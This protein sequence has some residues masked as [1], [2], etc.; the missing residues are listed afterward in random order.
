VGCVFCLLRYKQ[1]KLVFVFVLGCPWGVFVNQVLPVLHNGM[2]SYVLVLNVENK[3]PISCR[4]FL[5]PVKHLPDTENTDYNKNV[6]KKGK[7]REE[8]IRGS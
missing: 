4:Y 7:Q 8:V 1:Y 3:G 2:T 6:T 5:D